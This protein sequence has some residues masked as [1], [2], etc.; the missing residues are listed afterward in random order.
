MQ[1]QV[2]LAAA[3]AGAPA[4]AAFL[5]QLYMNSSS[6]T[7]G[8]GVIDPDLRGAAYHAAVA[9]LGGLSASGQGLAVAQAL[10]PGHEPLQ[11]IW[12]VRS[13][14]TACGS[15]TLSLH[16]LQR[17]TVMF[18]L[19]REPATSSAPPVLL[20]RTKGSCQAEFS[21]DKI[22]A[23]LM[24]RP[25][26]STARRLRLTEGALCPA[27]LALGLLCATDLSLLPSV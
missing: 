12:I 15:P 5:S 14:C 1:G 24:P 23:F 26:L 11:V 19:L 2:L 22:T 20:Q 4:S 16:C 3:F 6:N 21:S 18:T 27:P 9:Q 25:D 10:H 7:R 13:G 8:P 17:Y